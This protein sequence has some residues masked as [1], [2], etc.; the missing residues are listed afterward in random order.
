M[1]KTNFPGKERFLSILRNCPIT[2]VHQTTFSFSGK[3]TVHPLSLS[4]G[5]GID[6][7]DNRG[8][9]HEILKAVHRMDY[10]LK[11]PYSMFLGGYTYEEIAEKMN[12][13]VDVVKER[14]L[15]ARCELQNILKF[16]DLQKN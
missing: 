8:K 4:E 6:F 16:E 11:T 3:S 12:I 14:I 1:R 2:E 13:S 9:I 10:N 5:P 15:S 7:P